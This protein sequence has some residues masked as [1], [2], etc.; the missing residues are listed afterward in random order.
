MKRSSKGNHDFSILCTNNPNSN[1]CWRN[2]EFEGG[3]QKKTEYN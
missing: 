2:L 1:I 3:R